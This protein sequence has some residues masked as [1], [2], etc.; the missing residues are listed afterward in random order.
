MIY[1]SPEGN[2]GERRAFARDTYVRRSDPGMVSRSRAARAEARPMPTV[3]SGSPVIEVLC[4]QRVVPRDVR[5]RD[6]RSEDARTL[7]TGEKHRVWISQR[8]LLLGPPRRSSWR[9]Q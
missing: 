2:T 9:S 8:D 7:D 3:G 6:I 1:F 4:G 5:E